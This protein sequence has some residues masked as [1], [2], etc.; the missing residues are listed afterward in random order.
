MAK[1]KS[2]AQQPQARPKPKLEKVFDC[3]FCNHTQC[4]EI[5][6]DNDKKIGSLACRICDTRYQARINYLSAP[7][8]VYCEWI[9]ECEKL[10]RG[11]QQEHNNV[12]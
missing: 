2:R 4:V 3:P 1:K 6:I 5:K 12:I 11:N 10:N 8:D 9:D 7:V